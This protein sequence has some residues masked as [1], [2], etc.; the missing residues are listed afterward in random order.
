[1]SLDQFLS[2][3]RI[4]VLGWHT[5]YIVRTYLQHLT[6]VAAGLI[7][8]ALCIDI[9]SQVPEIINAPPAATGIGILFR[10]VWFLALRSVD[11]GTKLFPVCCF[12]GT[13]S[14]E[15]ALARAGDRRVISGSGWTPFQCVL[16]ALMLGLGLGCFL[17]CIDV[18]L[19]PASMA[20][21]ASGRLGEDG[22]RFDRTPNSVRYWFTAADKI[23]GAKLDFGPPVRLLNVAVYQVSNDGHLLR[24]TTAEAATAEGGSTEWRLDGGRQWVPGLDRPKND[25]LEQM[26]VGLDPLWLAHFGISPMYLPQPILKSLARLGEGS[27]QHNEYVMWI[28]LRYLDLLLPACMMLLACSLALALLSSRMTIERILALAISGYLMHVLMRACVLL[29]GSGKLAPS[30]AAFLTPG[31][32]ATLIVAVLLTISFRG[33]GW[34][35]SLKIPFWETGR[36]LL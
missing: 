9:S 10:I 34:A 28:Y 8:A 27:F 24:V 22:R 29:G 14:A 7:I 11:I 12:L 30:L 6:M 17:Y 4:K 31:I 1:V 3:I 21:Q 2:A 16:P 33:L 15:V 35:P 18:Y 36:S 20:A 23:I 5:R 25:R 19:R 13:L 32:V 26:N